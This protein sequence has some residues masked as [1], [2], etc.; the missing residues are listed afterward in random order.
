M[1]QEQL[2]RRHTRMSQGIWAKRIVERL[3][4]GRARCARAAGPGVASLSRGSAASR[5]LPRPAG[6]G[7]HGGERHARF[8]SPFQPV[9]C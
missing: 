6:R 2:R 1:E 3:R 4:G 8:F 9:S 5:L 7:R